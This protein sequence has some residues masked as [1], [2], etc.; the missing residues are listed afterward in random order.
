VTR[1]DGSPWS[2]STPPDAGSP[3]DRS[4]ATRAGAHVDEAGVR[5]MFDQIA[6]VYDRLNTVMTLG[7]DG[8][9]RRAAV[10]AAGLAPGDRAIDVACGT[11]KLASALAERVGSLGR[12]VG[13]DL[14]PS[15]VAHA[16]RRQPGLPQLEFQV[17]NAL[18]LAF[19]AGTFDAATIAF[20]LRNLAGFEAGFRELARVVRPGGRVVCLELTVP[21]PRWWGRAFH[22]A[23]RRLAPVLGGLAGQRSAYRYLPASLDGFP[24]PSQL[25]DSMRTAGLVEIRWRRLGLGT[26]ALHVGSVPGPP[27]AQ[28]PGEPGPG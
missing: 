23:F 6:P 28:A 14:A 8:R 27:A 4:S 13:V 18:A 10:A 2:P 7:A 5:A 22:A 24:D 21:R 15:M 11:G 26:V 19:E 25:A 3:R 1:P 16:R 9:W 17:G 20:G 12:V